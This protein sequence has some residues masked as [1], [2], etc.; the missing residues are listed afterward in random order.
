MPA[1]AEQLLTFHLE[2]NLQ[3][4]RGYYLPLRLK[5]AASVFNSSQNEDSPTD[6]LW[7]T[8]KIMYVHCERN[9]VLRKIQRNK[10]HL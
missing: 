2:S 5:I 1:R 6:F 9:Q 3:R 8:I 4:Y 10:N 7:S